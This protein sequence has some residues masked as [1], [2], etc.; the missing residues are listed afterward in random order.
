LDNV[1]ELWN[2]F[3]GCD[4]HDKCVPTSRIIYSGGAAAHRP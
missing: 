2:K 4:S 3:T 1:L